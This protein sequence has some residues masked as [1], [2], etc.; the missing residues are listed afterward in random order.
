M[1]LIRKCTAYLEYET[2]IHRAYNLHSPLVDVSVCVYLLYATFTF[3][4]NS[5]TVM[6]VP[7]INYDSW[8]AVGSMG[9]EIADS[10]V[11]AMNK[12]G[13]PVILWD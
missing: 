10:Q 13:Q 7:V 9:M 8:V 11:I 1:P 3:A 5:I 6:T 12:L 4:Q 2:L